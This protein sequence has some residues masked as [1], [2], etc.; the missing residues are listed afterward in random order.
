[1]LLTGFGTPVQLTE[2]VGGP[3][4]VCIPYQ[5]KITIPNSVPVTNPANPFFDG[6]HSAPYTWS[7]SVDGSLVP[8]GYKPKFVYHD[9]VALPPCG[10]TLPS[11][12]APICVLTI[13]QDNKTK[14]VFA[15]GRALTNGSYQ[16]G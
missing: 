7:I 4:S 9:G 2:E 13:T 5:S 15:T 3:C 14:T 6:V 11:A 10:T 1:V 12:S 16:F 8:P